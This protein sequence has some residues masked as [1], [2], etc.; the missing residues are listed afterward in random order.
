MEMVIIAG[1]ILVFLV[2]MVIGFLFSKDARTKRALA[3]K[4]RVSIKDIE[5]GLEVKVSGRLSYAEEPLVAPLTGRPCACWE[6]T[7]EEYR[8]SGNSGSWREIIREQECQP[9]FIDDDTE[10]ALVRDTIP[11]VAIEKDGHFK[12][13][14]FNDASDELESFLYEHGHQSVG[15]LGFNRSLRYKEGV[16]EEGEDVAAAGLAHREPDPGGHGRSGGYRDAPTIVV[17]E[18]PE[19]GQCMLSDSYETLK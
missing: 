12:S 3:G 5:E 13:G 15:M 1:F 17:I 2:V 6:V 11:I 19:G 16:L 4:Q 7:V 10:R 14:T 18:A 8:K 9:F